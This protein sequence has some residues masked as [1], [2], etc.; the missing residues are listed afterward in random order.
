MET[1]EHNE[2]TESDLRELAAD[3]IAGI[4]EECRAALVRE[5]LD[6]HQGR[7]AGQIIDLMQD[8]AAARH[9]PT[10]ENSLR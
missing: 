1:V 6:N 4:S 8:I 10:A 5:T 9:Y 7:S 2:L 3:T